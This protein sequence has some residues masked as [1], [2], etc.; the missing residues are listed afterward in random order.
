MRRHLIVFYT[1]VIILIISG[2]YAW[3]HCEWDWVSRI[4]SVGVILGI[5]IERWN[6]LVGRPLTT[7]AQPTERLSILLLCIGTFVA[8]FG[9][10]LGKTFFG[11]Q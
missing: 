6:V 11:C 10:L 7:P 3:L 2:R 9:E 8:G 5:V 1:V 4:S